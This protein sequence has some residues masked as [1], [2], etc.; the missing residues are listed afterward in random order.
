MTTNNSPNAYNYFATE[1][2]NKAYETVCTFNIQGTAIF[3]LHKNYFN[4]I[5]VNMIFF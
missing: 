1:V 5:W 3:R 4:I 2:S